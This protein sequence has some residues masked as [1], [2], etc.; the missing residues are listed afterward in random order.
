MW[1]ARELALQKAHIIL[2]ATG[3]TINVVYK[4]VLC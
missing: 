3:R 2:A 4:E 1:L